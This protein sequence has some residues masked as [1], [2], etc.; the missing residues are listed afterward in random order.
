MKKVGHYILLRSLI[1]S[2]LIFANP[3]SANV[4][5]YETFRTGTSADILVNDF[6]SDSYGNWQVEGTAFG[7]GPAQGTLSGQM[8]VTGYQGSR[9]VNSFNNGDG[10]T[11]VLTSPEFKIERKY[12]NF[13]IGG[14][15]HT[16][17]TCMNLLVDGE[18]V[19]TATGDNTQ[20]GGSEALDW[21]SWSVADLIG[22][23]AILKIVDDYT[24]GWGHI[25]V[26]QIVQSNM[27]K[28]VVIDK[29]MDLEFNAKYLI[30]PVKNGA[31]KRWISLYVNNIKVREFDIELATDKADFW[32]YLDVSEF[33][34][35]PGYLQIDK[36]YSDWQ[37][38]L[39][40]VEVS[41]NFPGQE[42]MYKEQRRPQIHFTS[43]R[44]W[45]NDTNGMVYYDGKY[46]MFYQHNPYGWG[47][48]NMT[49]GHAV[50]TD[51][52]H[53]DEWGDAIHP[54]EL[55]TIFSGSAVV[56]RQNTS[57]LQ[58]GTEKPL[59]AFYTSAGNNGIWSSGQPFSQSMAY[60][61]DGGHS[62]LKYPNNPVIGSIAGGTRDPKAFWHE[63]TG[64]W[65]LALWIDGS[66]LSIF[67]STDLVNWERKSD[68]D[69][70]FECPEL[71][72]LAI[73]GDKNNTKWVVY[74]ASGDY[75]IGSFD[76]ETFVPES[77]K[78]K[79]EY[80]NCFYASQTFNDMP[81]SDGR[82]VQIGWG[83]GVDMHDMPFNQ[84][85]LFPVV[86]SLHS[87][88]EG[89][90][91][92]V[93]PIGEIESL[94]GKHNQWQ[95]RLIQPG[96]YQVASV[97]SELLHVKAEL[98]PE[99][100]GSFGFNINGYDVL[101]NM[102]DN[103]LKCNGCSAPLEL[104]DGKISLEIVVDRMSIEVYANGGSVYMPVKA[105]Q[106][107]NAKALKLIVNDGSLMV[108]NLD[109]YELSS[110]WQ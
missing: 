85:M 48:G 23:T 83:R 65:V 31:A 61:T 98:T 71:F 84:M 74:G 14:G 46:H 3:L 63:A 2:A 90:R 75:K 87:T 60:S 56:D 62:W 107:G 40:A 57:G 9:L 78:I 34:G 52:L 99:D 32:V 16:G 110:V 18:I 70:F 28:K 50:S 81:E 24:G 53:W 49:W 59:V 43:R 38:G 77:A 17:K 101:C 82:R 25:N 73:D 67:N 54:D 11:G 33:A 72:E 45:V 21:N 5:A 47:W 103:K 109:I 4:L 105:D 80:G 102:S 68:I 37:M 64:K 100:A 108:D 88:D 10:S 19:R 89:L 66:T 22:K 69:G 20:S 93:N 106:T 58:S 27:Q 1:L 39:N 29:K 79:F 55:G 42:E 15:G 91:V 41:D 12:I 26:D 95:D 86:L 97:N 94:H 35:T 30:L 96:S 44:G 92:F 76:G 36:Y 8:E 6:E 51:M 7:S 104:V 13:L